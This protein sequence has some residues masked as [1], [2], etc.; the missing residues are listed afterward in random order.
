MPGYSAVLGDGV[1]TLVYIGDAI[2][3][4]IAPSPGATVSYS[5][6]E[7]GATGHDALRTLTTDADL[8]IEPSSSYY[9]VSSAGASARVRTF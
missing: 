3:L 7:S 9:W 8:N 2:R 5:P 6:V 1:G 4:S